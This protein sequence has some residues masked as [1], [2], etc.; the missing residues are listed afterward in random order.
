MRGNGTGFYHFAMATAQGHKDYFASLAALEEDRLRLYA[1]EASASL[2]RQEEIEQ[3]DEISFD[4]YLERY[5]SDQGCS[6]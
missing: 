1:D 6:D 5:Y 4:E 2:E 3:S